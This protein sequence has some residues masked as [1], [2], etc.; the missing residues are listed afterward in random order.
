MSNFLDRL[1]A[2]RA[3]TMHTGPLQVS[4]P[5]APN[6]A[7]G[8]PREAGRQAAANVLAWHQVAAFCVLLPPARD[9]VLHWH[10]SWG[11]ERVRAIAGDTVAGAQTFATFADFAAW[12]EG[13]NDVAA[14]IEV[15]A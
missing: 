6:G 13:V 12:L 1:A 2:D 11:S 9:H 5:R 7:P 10:G 14:A 15:E 8:G 4:V 3:A